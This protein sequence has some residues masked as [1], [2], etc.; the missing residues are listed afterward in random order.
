[1]GQARIYLDHTAT[2]PLCR[3]AHEE[4]IRLLDE[5]LANPQSPH[6][7]GR[8]AKDRLEAARSRV[9]RALGVRPR[10]IVFT[11]GGTEACAI[12]LRGA[13]ALAARFGRKRLVVSAVEYPV[14]LETAAALETEGFEVVRVP[15]DANGLISGPAFLDAV[16]EE[17]SVAALMLANHEMGA[18]M[19]VAE[20]AAGCA[21]RRVPL[22]CDAVLGPGRL[23]CAP[24]ALGAPLIAYSAHKFG[25]PAGAGALYV[26]RGTRLE[27]WLHGGVQEERLRPGTENVV[28]WTGLAAALEDALDGAEAARVRNEENVRTFLEGLHPLE[29]W[30]VIGP[31]VGVDAPRL[32]GL[33]TLELE[34]VEGEAVMI[35]MD[36]EGFS[37]STGSTCALGSSDPSPSLLAMGM[38]KQRAAATIRISSGHGI[39]TEHMKQAASTLSRIVLRLRALA[40]R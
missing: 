23:P 17:T 33:V 12:G 11:S 40:R 1:M 8:A 28:A 22:L 9:A 32:P 3:S 15:V 20:V 6:L 16:T 37:V 24:A 38:S 4:M 29:G 7:E 36:L 25:G 2:A 27:P 13:A 31:P 19:P 5:P 26:Q 35:N 30:R 34:G 10:E 14:V 18:V 21:E 39:G